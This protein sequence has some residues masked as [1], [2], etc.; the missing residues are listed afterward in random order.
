MLAMADVAVAVRDAGESASWW[1]EK[2]G[3]AVHTIDGPEGHAVMVAPPGERFLLHLCEGF[4]PVDPGNTGIAFVT[5]EFERIAA[6]LAAAG[7]TF[8]EP[9]STDGARGRAMF[10]DPDGN[11]FWLIKAPTALVRRETQRR[12]PNPSRPPRRTRAN[13]P[14]KGAPRAARLR[15]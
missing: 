4:E 9:P 2:V 11:V 13:G 8:A 3:F 14:R 6:R 7:V 10:S 15:R 12:A 5:D 1:K